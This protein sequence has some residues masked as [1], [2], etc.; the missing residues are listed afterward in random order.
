LFGRTELR[1]CSFDEFF[2]FL[3]PDDRESTLDAVRHVARGEDYDIIHR[4]VWPDQS[5][6]WLR[7][8]GRLD[9][10]STC[11]IGMAIEVS[12]LQRT[13]EIFRNNER[14]V[15]TASMASALAHEINNPLEI[16]CN[17]LFLLETEPSSNTSKY[18]LEV[19]RE[20]YDRIATIT[21]QMLALHSQPVAPTTFPLQRCLHEVINDFRRRADEKNIALEFQC[22]DDT[23]VNGAETDIQRIATILIENAFESTTDGCRIYVRAGSSRD[24]T[25]QRRDGFRI[26]VADNGCGIPA[27]MRSRIF[28]PFTTD[29]GIR[30]CGLGLWACRAL[31]NRYAG[32]IRFRSRN[33]PSA[34][35]TI[36]SVFLT[37][38]PENP[39]THSRSNVFPISRL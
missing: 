35:G 10:R 28:H 12:W 15:A 34:H 20:A 16:L 33:H 37:N 27:G 2:T 26:T 31:V 5:V 8:K 25:R 19:A 24:W 17:A 7:C 32:T 3:H 22:D 9:A 30:R 1:Q 39:L 18:P 36:F 21:R 11:V 14:L 29:K 4:V 6:H 23:V 38:L 13:E